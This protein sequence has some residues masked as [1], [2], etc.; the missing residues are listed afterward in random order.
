MK[1]TIIKNDSTGKAELH[2]TDPETG[3]ILINR[4]VT[5]DEEVFQIAY[6]CQRTKKA[7]DAMKPIVDKMV[8]KRIERNGGQ[9]LEFDDRRLIFKSF[10]TFRIPAESVLSAFDD[11]DQAIMILTE[12]MRADAVTESGIK[13]LVKEGTINEEDAGR[14]LQGKI[15]AGARAY[16]Q[17]ERIKFDEKG[18]GV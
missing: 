2:V 7:I 1:A 9:P 8:E 6:W 3:E 13:R 11:K 10:P 12:A 17:V 4:P 14:I 5:T 16:A 18:Q 15:M